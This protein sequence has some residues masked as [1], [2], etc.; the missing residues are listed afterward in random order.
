[1]PHLSN[2]E[3]H[4]HYT[5]RTRYHPTVHTGARAWHVDCALAVELCRTAAF[6]LS[7][8][9]SYSVDQLRLTAAKLNGTTQ[10]NDDETKQRPAILAEHFSHSPHACTSASCLL[11]L[12]QSR[13][14]VS[15]NMSTTTYLNYDLFPPQ[16]QMFVTPV[17]QAP[18]VPYILPQKSG[19]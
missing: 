6:K 5:R 1:M 7:R 14:D 9:S 16:Q 17:L 2:M 15:A 18:W 19:I 12:W 8:P 13:A 3:L 11:L 10:P 4:F